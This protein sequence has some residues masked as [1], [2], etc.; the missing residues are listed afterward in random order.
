MYRVFL[1]PSDLEK[2]ENLQKR[3]FWFILGG[4]MFVT[5]IIGASTMRVFPGWDVVVWLIYIAGIIAIFI[6]PIYGVYLTIFFCLSGDMILIPWYPFNK[7]FSSAESFF[8]INSGLKFAAIELYLVVILLAWGFR[9]FAKKKIDFKLGPL[10]IPVIAFTVTAVYGLVYGIS[11]R[12]DTTIALWE[13]RAMFYMTLM[14]FFV[15][16]FVENRKQINIIVW[17]IML[18]NFV[19]GIVGCWYYLFYPNGSTHGSDGIM[20][21]G[22]SI[23]LNTLFVF[24]AALFL[25]NGPIKK[26]L[27]LIA[28]S[29]PSL[30]AYLVNQRRAS[31]VSLGIAMIL[32]GV[33]LFRQNRSI[34][35]KIAPPITVFATLFLAAT[36]NNTGS[37]GLPARGIKSAL[38]LGVSER[39]K[40]S[41]VYRDIENVNT[42]FTI[43]QVPFTGLGFGNKFLIISPLPDISFFVWYEYITHNSIMWVWMQVGVFGFMALLFFIGSTVAVGVHTYD[44]IPTGNYKAIGATMVLYIIMHFVY[45]YVDMSWDVQNL[46]YIGT[47]VG[48]IASLDQVMAKPVRGEPK[49]FRWMRDT[50]PDI[51]LAEDEI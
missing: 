31:F 4:V 5:V 51:V 1:P 48:I 44:R 24:V 29:L 10:G 34:F 20:E 21:H 26:K 33:A 7:N 13:C 2:Q 50:P 17:M 23:H 14:Y 35:W 25:F 38:G 41:N 40:A 22:A 16:N 3:D 11:K 18:G 42:D 36:W 45:A 12:G 49:R 46:T 15:V 6:E 32:L 28:F 43:H 30:F 47:A 39:D 9:M 27:L 37:A 19:Q 8:F